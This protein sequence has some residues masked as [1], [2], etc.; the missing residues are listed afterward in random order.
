[1]GKGRFILMLHA[2]LPFINHPDFPS[3]MEERWLFEAITETY[4]PLLQGFKRLKRD[5][6]NFKVTMSIT[7]PLMEMLANKD[8]QKKYL[9]YLSSSI[10]LAGNEISRTI[11]EHPAANKLAAHY[12]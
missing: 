2:H 12:L 3:F 4:I 1:M 10:E 11:S 6:V 5:G 8:L 9:N 7:P